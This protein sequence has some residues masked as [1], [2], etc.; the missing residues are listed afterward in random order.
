[1][2]D[3]LVTL[4]SGS[5]LG[6]VQQLVDELRN[7]GIRA[8]VVDGDGGTRQVNVAPADVA[9]AAT[10]LAE[11][12]PQ[13]GVRASAPRPS[14]PQPLQPPPAPAPPPA[15]LTPLTPSPP[16]APPPPAL[17]PPQRK[18]VSLWRVLAGLAFAW[19]ATMWAGRCARG[20]SDSFPRTPPRAQAVTAPIVVKD[21]NFRFKPPGPGW[22]Q[23]DAKKVSPVAAVVLKRDSPELMIMIIGEKGF[24]RSVT[25]ATVLEVVRSKIEP[26]LVEPLAEPTEV[27]VAGLKGLQRRAVFKPTAGPIKMVH[28]NTAIV[29]R[30]FAWQIL[31]NGAQHDEAAVRQVLAALPTSFELIDP[32]LTASVEHVPPPPFEAPGLGLEVALPLGWAPLPPEEARKS[33]PRALY[34]A[35]CEDERTFALY[36]LP[37]RGAPFSRDALERTGLK[38]FNLSPQGLPRRE[39]QVG[40]ADAVEY[41][42]PLDRGD[43]TNTFTFVFNGDTPFLALEGAR[44]RASCAPAL[45]LLVTKAPRGEPPPPAPGLYTLLGKVLAED[46]DADGAIVAFTAA[47]RQK[48]DDYDAAWGL[49]GL[50]EK[51][52]AHQ[53][54]TK[55]FTGVLKGRARSDAMHTVFAWHLGHSGQR[56]RALAQYDA[57]FKAGLNDDEVFSDYV[58][59]LEETRDRTKVWKVLKA[60]QKDHDT[61]RVAVL[62][63]GILSRQGQTKKAIALL[64]ERARADARPDLVSML[65]A[66]LQ[67]S[68]R[69]EEALAWADR[70]TEAYGPNAEVLAVR[71]ESEL[72][73]ERYAS[74][75]KSCESGLRL[76]PGHERLSRLLD[77]AMDR[78]GQGNNAGIREPIDPVPLPAGLPV[79]PP[80]AQE[81]NETTYQLWGRAIRFEPQKTY[82]QTDYLRVVVRSERDVESFST[83]AFTYDPRY[84]TA[85]LNSLR[86]LDAQGKELGRTRAEDCYLADA[87]NE[88]SANSSRTLYAPVPGLVVGATIDLVFSTQRLTAPRAMPFSDFSFSRSRPVRLAVLSVEGALSEVR[89]HHAQGVEQGASAASHRLFFVKAPPQLAYEAFGL[90][91]TRIAPVVWMTDGAATWEK[92]LAQYRKDLGALLEPD[93]T[94][95]ALA[96]SL[97]ARVPADQR[98]AALARHVSQNIVY[99][100]IEFGRGA[101]IPRPSPEVLKRK[102]GD[103]KDQSLLLWKLLTAAGIEADLALVHTDSVLL[104]EVPSLDQFNHM[105]VHVPSLPAKF[106]DPTDRWEDPSRGTPGLAGQEALLVRAG[107]PRFVTIERLPST[108][109]EVQVER[110]LVLD[111]DDLEVHETAE[112]RGWLASTLRSELAGASPRV[113]DERLAAWLG[114]GTTVQAVK[115]EDLDDV[116]RPLRIDVKYRAHRALQ[117]VGA[118]TM[119]TPP[120]AWE[121]ARMSAQRHERRLGPWAVRFPFRLTTLTWVKPR[122]GEVVR[123]VEPHEVDNAMLRFTVEGQSRGGTVGRAFTYERLRSDGPAQGYDAWWKAN[124]GALE[125]L[126]QPFV[127]EAGSRQAAGA[128]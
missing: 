127:L 73:L 41:V 55:A 122:P 10:L 16:A 67:N 80:L 28:Y 112:L 35:A 68:N 1:M 25:A 86:V 47:L 54:V 99:K 12:L 106:V 69:D 51:L 85:F 32:K 92:E 115:L 23:L 65:M 21:Y 84:E 104:R 71:A 128:K 17:P 103:C 119:V 123:A 30:G 91:Y 107:T 36:A 125:A 14:A 45:P 70:S 81:D 29:S 72:Q 96:K 20:V 34:V 52:G 111:G 40:G 15:E 118:D 110:E 78:L 60:Y 97:V 113:R 48:P 9:R 42:T 61:P 95:A 38:L 37:L 66:L 87:A 75:R 27:E 59:L 39:L 90:D 79:A 116:Q 58:H 126:T 18:P 101:Q 114:A 31:V 117:R 89:F 94:T 50:G 124:E 46:R 13:G 98:A 3:A 108:E 33:Y 64:E 83:M 105:I 57:T 4:Y 43:G 102:Y 22:I 76:S 44:S 6:L 88:D 62:E 120:S 2:S 56:A 121:Q 49:V 63:A 82:T 109:P 24:D 53:Q 19:G 8:V 7:L 74:A 77:V 26:L 100:A 5:D 93:D 11:F